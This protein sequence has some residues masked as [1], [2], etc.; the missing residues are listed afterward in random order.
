MPFI[1]ILLLNRYVVGGANLLVSSTS[2]PAR[3][4]GEGIAYLWL[5]LRRDG[6]GRKSKNK[7]VRGDGNKR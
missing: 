3:P 7:N 1:N 4:F 5:R 2:Q 6:D